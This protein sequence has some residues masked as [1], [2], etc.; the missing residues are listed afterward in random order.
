MR[1]KVSVI[2]PLYNVQDF[3]VRCAESLFKQTLDETEFIFVDDASTDKTIEILKQCAAKH[4]VRNIKI[5]RHQINSGSATARNSGLDAARGEYITFADGD[6]WLEPNALQELYDKAIADDLDIVY[7]N[8]Y[9]DR[10]QSVKLIEQ[11][12]GTTGK[13]C[14]LAMI[15]MR[16]HGSSCNKLIKREFILN[17]G[18]RYING[19]DLYED[20]GLNVR[21]F[22]LTN[23]IGFINKAYYHYMQTNPN[24]II[25]TMKGKQRKRAME[26]IGNIT[27]A[28]DF[29]KTI[30][31][32][33]GDIERAANEW[34][35]IA[36]NELIEN[37]KVSLLRWILTFPEADRAIWKSKQITFNLKLLLYHLHN[38]QICL[39]RAQKR[40]IGWL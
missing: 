5:I 27:V 14:V 1:P 3:I 6:D 13:E 31:W 25:S 17:S 18:Q 34:K 36:K 30:G 10:G 29:L 35:L 28:C 15:G 23:R 9:E 38:K 8:Y 16:M 7:C 32:M 24:S 37:N 40:I 11:Y 19:L 22:A 4:P 33:Q 21:L 2:I 12:R 20:V 26:R 39:Y